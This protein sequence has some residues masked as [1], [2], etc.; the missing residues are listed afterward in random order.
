MEK[1]KKANG[2]E[3]DV[4]ATIKQLKKKDKDVADVESSAPLVPAMIPDPDQISFSGL[5]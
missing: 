2:E 1:C 4:K 3:K 5:P